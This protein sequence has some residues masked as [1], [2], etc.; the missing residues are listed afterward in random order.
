MHLAA[1]AAVAVAEEPSSEEAP[2]EVRKSD[3]RESTQATEHGPH[4][5][6]HSQH[7]LVLQPEV[8]CDGGCRVEKAVLTSL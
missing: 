7:L 8:L 2:H 4:F 1:I 3:S 6:T 5:Q